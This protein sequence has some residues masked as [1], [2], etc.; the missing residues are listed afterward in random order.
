MLQ[1][2]TAQE[3]APQEKALKVSPFGASI[4]QVEARSVK[5]EEPRIGVFIC[6]CGHNIADTVDV[7][8]VAEFAKTLPNVV[9]AEHYMFMCSKP[10]TALIKQAIKDKG[11]N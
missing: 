9:H 7:E 11:L 6:H 1:E 8:K 3:T 2:N 5:G 4:E 10:G